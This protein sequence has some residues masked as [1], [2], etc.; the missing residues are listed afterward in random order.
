[1]KVNEKNTLKLKEYLERK[2]FCKTFMCLLKRERLQDGIMP[3]WFTD[4]VNWTMSE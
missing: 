4:L 3:Q 1:M 2:P